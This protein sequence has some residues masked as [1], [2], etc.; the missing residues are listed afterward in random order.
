MNMSASNK[1]MILVFLG[2]IVVVAAYFLGVSPM[3]EEK[4]SIDKE[5][6]SLQTRYNELQARKDKEEDYKQ[7]IVTYNE[8]FDEKLNVFPATL[9]QEYTIEFVE[10]LRQAYD[11]DATSLTLSEPAQFY[12]LGTAV[13]A[14]TE[15]S[16]EGEE[17]TEETTTTTDEEETVIDENT[18][19][20]Y[21]AEFPIS[22]TG[23][24][25]GIKN[26]LSYVA[27]YRYR[28]TVDTTQ[29]AYDVSTDTYSGEI[30]LTCYSIAGP[31]RS[32]DTLNIDVETGVSNLFTGG[33]SA[34][35]SSSS[36]NKYDE[37]EGASIASDYD[38]YVMLNPADSD[39]SAKSI[40]QDGKSASVVS[41]T[42]NEEE[43]LK[44]EFYEKDGKNYVQYTLGESSYEA[45]I[46]S[47]EDA[48][49]YVTSTSRTGTA[50]LSAVNVTITNTMSIPVYI[51]VSGDDATSPR[52]NVTSKSGQ[53]KVYK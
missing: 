7:G 39:V 16:A 50:D 41:S 3:L 31:D 29:I 14:D 30:V 40:G 45:E 19:V 17:Q 15:A 6:A 22:Y 28:M 25:E 10:G 11:F 37:D 13:A 18:Y 35:S 36:L 5:V 33:G 8:K 4:E 2:I 23:S 26:V 48:T 52:F 47:S 43:A 46:T 9:N 51:K 49:V 12:I 42:A 21:T 32:D 34:G 24:Y 38:L 44:L 53:V 1:N 20:C 27:D